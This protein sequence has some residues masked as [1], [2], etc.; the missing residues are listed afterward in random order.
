MFANTAFEAR[1]A[2][3]ITTQEIEKIWKTLES[4]G[5]AVVAS[6]DCADGLVRHFESYQELVSYENPK[7]ASITGMEIAG[8]SSEPHQR[9]EISFGRRI[10]SPITVS[11]SGEEQVV[12]TIRRQTSDSLDSIRPWYSRI[13]MLDISFFWFAMFMILGLFFIFMLPSGGGPAPA[14][15]FLKAL[16]ALAIVI[17][18]CAAIWFIISGVNWIRNTVFPMRAFAIGHGLSRHQTL[19]QV[20]WVV[21][22]GLVVGV[23]ASILATLMLGAY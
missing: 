9:T 3:V 15:P 18:T 1:Q 8:R 14:V 23:V 13:A 16:K 21:V 20:R 22:V 4:H 7:R 12:S 11:I 2:F 6:V 17:V 19:D 5:L 10:S